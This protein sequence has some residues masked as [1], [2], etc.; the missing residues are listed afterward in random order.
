MKK[1]RAQRGSQ[2]R[3]SLQV[4]D[5]YRQASERTQ[6]FTAANVLFDLLGAAAGRVG[7]HGDD[8]VDRA[9]GLVD[10]TKT[11]FQQLDG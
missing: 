1:Q 6:V 11:A 7:I 2:P 3:R 5:A 9:V 10:A 4:F 8:C